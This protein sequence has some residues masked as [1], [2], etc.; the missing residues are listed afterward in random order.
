[1]DAKT[2]QQSLVSSWQPHYVDMHL[3]DGVKLLTLGDT[4][5]SHMFLLGM[6]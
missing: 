1:M 6:R 3:T 2:T 5:K 4:I